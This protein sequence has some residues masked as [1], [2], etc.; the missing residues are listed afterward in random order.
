MGKKIKFGFCIFCIALL[1]SCSMTSIMV[2]AASPLITKMT[3]AV[4]KN[5]DVELVKD[6]IAPS[7]LMIDGLIE[8]SPEN[9]KNLLLAAESYSGYT[10][11]FVEDN[12]KKRAKKLYKKARDYALRVLEKK[13]WFK[14]AINMPLNDF[15]AKIKKFNKKDV[16]A[17]FWAANCWFQL[18]SVS[19]DSMEVFADIP[20]AEAML[21]RVIELDEKYYYGSAHIGLGTYYA[22]RPQFLGGNPEKAK[23]HFEKAFSIS[24]SKF[25]M[26]HLFYAKFYAVQIQ[27]KDLYIKTLETIINSPENLLPEKNFV[28]ELMR[29]KA[30]ALMKNLDEYF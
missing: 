13:S 19:M 20:K 12:N 4:N 28:N 9:E 16:P 6:G 7:L 10:F 27:D 14:G 2:K 21:K 30:K 24:D 17:L 26:A 5:D 3:D 1:C 25:L 11:A 23:Y 29:V 18:I 22:A 15:S 8:A